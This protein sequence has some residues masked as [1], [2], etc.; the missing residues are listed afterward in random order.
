MTFY[1]TEEE[2]NDFDKYIA[3]ME[4]QGA[5]QAGVAQKIPPKGWEARKTYDGISNILVPTPL[6]QVVLGGVGVITQHHKKKKA[7]TVAEPQTPGNHSGPAR[8]GVWGGHRRR[9]HTLP[10]LQHVEDHVCMAHRGH[11][12]LQHQLCAF[13][14]PKTWYAVPPD[15]DQCLERLAKDLFPASASGCGAFLR[16]KFAL[17]S[18]T[19]LRD[20]GIS[21]SWV[22][23]EAGEFMVTFPYGYHT[24]FNHGFNCAEAIK[25]ATPHWIDYGKAASQC[26][27]R[28][29][30]VSFPMDVFVHTLQPERYELWKRGQEQVAVNDAAP[31]VADSQEPDAWELW[32]MR[33]ATLG[34]LDL[35]PCCA[36]RPARQVAAG[37]G[38]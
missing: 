7:M 22:M 17:M 26:S 1:P 19:V 9:Q 15:N 11:G 5:H 10:V 36:P 23:Q 20:N 28:E 18:P 25:F 2:F 37:R 31:R 14:E 6:Q 35:P 13:G 21:F 12:L 3:Y 38:D 30:R 33:R 29:A 34:L 27:C 24:G 16:Q 8:A 32:V 4:S